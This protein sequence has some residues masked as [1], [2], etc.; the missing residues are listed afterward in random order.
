[1]LYLLSVAN[2]GSDFLLDS[3]NVPGPD[4]LMASD[5]GLEA[6]KVIREFFLCVFPDSVGFM[7]S[8]EVIPVL[9]NR[10]PPS[11]MNCGLHVLFNLDLLLSHFERNGDLSG[12]LARLFGSGEI[13]DLSLLRPVFLSLVLKED[14][15]S[16]L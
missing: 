10:Q 2:G 1:M 14:C 3:L 8:K 11:S 4:P 12:L 13:L 15:G 7:S 5:S 16:S 9:V 6:V